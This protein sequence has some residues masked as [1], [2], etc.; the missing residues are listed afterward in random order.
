[1]ADSGV[2]QDPSAHDMNSST[3]TAVELHSEGE[4]NV[5]VRKDILFDMDSNVS[6][7]ILKVG[8]R[9]TDAEPATSDESNIITK[10]DQTLNEF[11]QINAL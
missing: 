2:L 6:S 9:S 3:I 4:T 5:P 1:M 8:T 11:H 7:A 10:C